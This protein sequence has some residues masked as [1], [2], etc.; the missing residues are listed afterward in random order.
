MRH[1]VDLIDKLHHEA[2]AA[3]GLDDFGDTSYL[4]GL[5]RLI[6]AFVAIPGLDD[7]QLETLTGGLVTGTLMSRL[8]TEEAWKKH[9]H[10][11]QIGLSA[12]VFIVGIPRTGTTALHQLLSVDPRFQVG[13]K[14]LHSYPKPRPPRRQWSDDPDYQRA[15]A[16]AEAMPEGLQ[17]TH[18]VGPGD[19]DECLVPMAQSFV[20]NYFG[21]QASIP[22]YDEW[23][24]TQDA[25]PSLARYADFLRL[26][27]S[28]SPEKTWLLKNPSHLLCID[29][30][31]AVF[32]GARVIQTHRDPQAALGSVVSVLSMLSKLIG[33]ERD[34]REIARREISLWAEGIRRTD[35]ARRGRESSFHDVDYRRFTKDPLGVVREI[36][37]AFGLD[38]PVEVAGEMQRW[39]DEHPKDRH[40]THVYEPETLGVDPDTIDE[41]FGTYI[42][43]RELL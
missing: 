28:T 23:M 30:L 39:L 37:R 20:S 27:G 21:S 16:E 12:P 7:Q 34:P 35:Q 13:E 40:G 36:Y 33:V 38:L 18:F 10:W 41:H 15:V 14:W 31:F 43:E 24:L 4:E 6:E 2:S 9:A 25:T 26:L 8:R 1:S 22:A 3:T 19:A 11:D 5:N 17:T 32:P 42:K 29:E